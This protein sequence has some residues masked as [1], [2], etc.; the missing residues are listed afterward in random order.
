MSAKIVSRKDGRSAVAAAAYRSGVELVDQRTG[1]VHDYTRKHGVDHAQ[2]VVPDG[3]VQLDREGLWNMVEAKNKR[4]DAQLAREFQLALPAELDADQR[5]DLAVE[6]AQTL[7]DRYRI[8]A[9]VA[10]H[11][12]D[13]DGDQR[14][15]H[16]HILTT[17]NTV[18]D[19]GKLGNKCRAFNA[20]DHD[21]DK[22]R[23][24]QP[25]EIEI[26]RQL[27]Q[28]LANR[29]LEQAGCAERI[30]HRSYK[31][32]GID[33]QPSRHLGVAATAM[34][35]QGKAT[36][37]GVIHQATREKQAEQIAEN[38]LLI[39][40]KL[41]ASQIIFT[42]GDLE[43]EA[44]RYLDKSNAASAIESIQ[45]SGNLI[46]LPGRIDQDKPTKPIQ[47]ITTQGGLVRAIE[48]A[49]ASK[50]ERY[51]ELTSAVMEHH[52]GYR[53]N[54]SGTGSDSRIIAAV[55]R[56]KTP[57]GLVVEPGF[58]PGN[59]HGIDREI[60]MRGLFGLSLANV[61]GPGAHHQEVWTN[62]GGLLQDDVAAYPRAREGDH[63]DV[64]G[65]AKNGPVSE[66][67]DDQDLI[68]SKEP[69]HLDKITDRSTHTAIRNTGQARWDQDR[70][71]WQ[72]IDPNRMDK[73]IDW[74]PQEHRAEATRQAEQYRP[75]YEADAAQK[76]QQD[77]REAEAA[78]QARE[79]R[80]SAINA[81]DQRQQLINETQ[82]RIVTDTKEWFR[83]TESRLEE[84]IKDLG[85]RPIFGREQWETTRR[86]LEQSLE[87][88]K[89]AYIDWTNDPATSQRA[90]QWATATVDANNQQ[91]AELAQQ[92]KEII[93]EENQEARYASMERDQQKKQSKDQEKSRSR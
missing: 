74:L 93:A 59:D 5:R 90:R 35:R 25:N 52:H 76:Q 81:V 18:N 73:L 71:S 47:T 78:R 11:A 6:F 65:T 60:S 63:L 49:S 48:L 4:A 53:T 50:Y 91:L 9:D 3:C 51:S 45:R 39:A 84:S 77:K 10:I 92:G 68:Q 7:A 24:D 69:I 44:S 55:A 58:G 16:A 67:G 21:R 27:W 38:P 23:R 66:Q 87:K 37:R 88:T 80:N 8:V 14:N 82:V 79:Q 2:V 34:E 41:A 1:Q 26:T 13:R 30:D 12:P 75:E 86:A 15:Y 62:A 57:G 40:E 22:S 43:K 42:R 33:L 54:P 32:Q 83:E 36:D 70:E 56:G 72:V 17:T 29:Y 46:I 31:K 61:G 85:N 28:D 64:R 89:S 20:I 19:D